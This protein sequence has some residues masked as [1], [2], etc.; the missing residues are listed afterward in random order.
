MLR[1][2]G[3]KWRLAPWV[4]SFFPEHKV[5]V[6][7][8]AGAG[9]VLMR[10]PRAN[11]EL[12]NDMDGEVCNLFRVLRDPSQAR[13]L[14]RLLSLT[15]YARSEY[16]AAYLDS[17]DTVEQ[18]RRTLIK[19]F[20]GFGS[21][22]LTATW[23]TGFRDNLTRGNG[24]PATDWGNFPRAIEAM[25]ARL[26]GV[27]VENRPALQIIKKHDTPSTLF[28]CDPP[29]PHS[30]RPGCVRR[31]HSYR[32]EM[33][34]EEHRELAATLREVKGMVVL[35]GYA[36]ELYDV[37][38]YRDWHRF[39]REVFAD[40]ARPRIEVLW[41]NDAAQKARQNVQQSFLTGAGSAG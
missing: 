15:P 34:D 14:E 3:G 12:I 4:I 21:D 35:S 1:Y 17:P 5:Y 25:T 31:K 6:E 36:C 40:A 37:E 11:G 23:L 22:G 24:I 27:V 18:A 26:R 2:H 19:S 28:Y 9:S 10:K 7:P 32:F 39:E 16:E 33:T 38:L 30:T 8:F 29:Y 13:E 20:M 41:I